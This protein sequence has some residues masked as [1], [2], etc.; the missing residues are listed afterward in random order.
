MPSPLSSHSN[1]NNNNK[2]QHHV[3]SL[4]SQ[5]HSDPNPTVL[6]QT[7]TN[8]TTTPSNS[9]S[10][11][12]RQYSLAPPPSTPHLNN[13]KKTRAATQLV[14]LVLPTGNSG[15]SNVDFSA[16]S[17]A[18]SA[19]TSF[20]QQDR[21]LPLPADG[22]AGTSGHRTEDIEMDQMAPVSG[23][24]RRRSTLTSSV[25]AAAPMGPS[26]SRG[27]SIGQ[28]FRKSMDPGAD[29]KISEESAFRP[30]GEPSKVEPSD[31]ERSFS[32]EDLH[33]DE[34]TGLT[35]K[36]R[37]RRRAKKKRNT[38]LDN[39][40]ARQHITDEER[41]E[42]DQNVARNIA[43]N[44][45][46][47]GLW[48]IFSLSISLYNKWMFDANNLNFAF[49]LF[50]TSAHML[51]Q[52]SL[53]SLVLYFI[54]SLRPGA[55]RNSDMGQSRHDSEPKQPLMTNLFYL[56]RIG[57][58]G[59]ATGLD[60]GLGN[61][62]LKFI[63]LTFYT[64]CKSS[65]LAFVLLFAFM[66]RLETPTWK[67]VAIIATM[68][69]GVVMMVAGEVEFKLNGF[70]LVISAAFFSGFRWGLTQILLLRNPA[71]SNPFSSIFYLAPVMFCTLLIIAIPVE[72]L[73]QL[74][75]G[76][77]AL[78]E[79]WGPVRAPLILIFPGTIAFLMTASEFALLKRSSV[80]TL[81][82]AG[83]FKEVVT[84]SAAAL[85]FNDKLTP[86]NIFGLFVTIAAIGCYNWIKFTKIRNEAQV[87]AHNKHGYQQAESGSSSDGG[88]ESDEDTGLL[89]H[90]EA[91][92]ERNMITVD[93]DIYPD[94]TAPADEGRPPRTSE[95]ASR[96]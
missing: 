45:V 12:P 40:I 56:T 1:N 85:V 74:I 62:S 21:K 5:P 33:S 95:H 32:D 61:A 20:Q 59:A 4:P 2:I 41:K 35:K 79:A 7:T 67:L 13:N 63:T 66:F 30:A 83:I 22:V 15:S 38:R 86:I 90:S 60:I 84:I 16:P 37:K 94:R 8:N 77:K 25:G 50:T 53:A 73:P 69:L 28:S 68:T 78:S 58:C 80:V 93:G 88:S 47:I 96:A 17:S 64:M 10:N 49:P 24:R 72:G 54:P 48:Y 51:V 27:R 11:N 57:P 39:R 36:D 9:S 18:S 89:A 82:I 71:T 46:L 19:T 44:C 87:E 26:H 31:D 52:F 92:D 55:G 23:H 3:H 65:S 14:T 70:V 91:E 81:S 43:I 29:G 6:Q 42:A 76:L 75:E 34:E